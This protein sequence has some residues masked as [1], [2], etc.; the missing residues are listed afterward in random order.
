MK[1]YAGM[2]LG[3]VLA[4]TA[5][6][7]API[8]HSMVGDIAESLLTPRA[9][10]AVAEIL[11]DQKMSD[12]EVG[13]WADII[14]GTRE[15]EERYPR[16]GSWH[17]VEFDVTL[18]YHDQFELKL[19]GDGNDIVSQIRRWRDELKS[20]VLE[21]EARLDGLRFLVHFVGDL[22]QPLHCAFRYGDMGGNMLPVEA[23][24]GRHY[25]YDADTPMDY[26]SNVHS[27]WDDA[28]VNELLAGQDWRKVSRQLQA[29]ITPSQMRWWSSD[30]PM[31]WAVDSYWR[32]R[33]DVYRW[34]DGT[35][36]P[37]K[38]AR[39]GMT[40]TSDNYIDAKLPIVREQLQKGGVRLAHALNM[41]FDPDYAGP[42]KEGEKGEE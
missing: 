17:F 37:Y 23:F 5:Q 11:G 29:E 30:D 36:L 18:R 16:N 34:A 27:V 33:K 20:G 6:A 24:Q 10:A 21:G 4:A 39:P 35:A 1:R 28:M 2:G 3:M 42:S 38:W 40:L 13:S 32:A 22:H 12:Y 26:A 9:R 7:W 41:A 31:I 25:S 8:G 19:P 14:R 15:Y